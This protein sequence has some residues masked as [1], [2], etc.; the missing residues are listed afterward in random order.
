MLV[1]NIDRNSLSLATLAIP[2]LANFAEVKAQESNSASP[3]PI[4]Q[5]TRL[6][7][8]PKVDGI[9][10]NDPAWTDITPNSKFTQVRPNEGLAAT[11]PTDVYIGFDDEKLYVGVM[12]YDDSPESIIVSD[13]RR[14]SPLN[15]TDSF[16]IIIDG[17]LDRQNGYVFGTNPS[18]MEFDAQVI[19]EGGSGGFGGRGGGTG[20][21]N[22]NWDTTWEVE[23]QIF[24]EGWSAEF[25]IPFV[26][27]RYLGDESQTW[28]I[29]FQ[30][31][32]RRN[33][34]ES[35]WAPLDRNFNLN[36]V[37]EAGYLEGIEV[38]SQRL[39]QLTPYALSLNEQGGFR[40]AAQSREEYGLSLIHI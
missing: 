6:S 33:N 18:G 26:A 29:N 17:L 23:A 34:E 10:I 9:I 38:P 22:L 28:G 14:D 11:Q 25:A 2:L 20:G 39:F 40:S 35:Y 19:N 5:A 8:P 12:A 27:L 3:R 7:R 15:D 1:C 4:A 32:I 24:D 13:S 16:R 30:R 36:R 31:N 37:S 21:F